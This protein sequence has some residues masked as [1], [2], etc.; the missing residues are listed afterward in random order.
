MKKVY[1]VVI[2]QTDGFGTYWTESVG[3]YE[4]KENAQNKV[5][6]LKLSGYNA[7]FK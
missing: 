2:M 3:T 1:D 7:F 5:T 6:E 4:T